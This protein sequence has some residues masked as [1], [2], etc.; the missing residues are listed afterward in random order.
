MSFINIAGFEKNWCVNIECKIADSWSL[1]NICSN[2]ID[3]QLIEKYL[4]YPK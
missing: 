3:S 2:A 4:E 1:D